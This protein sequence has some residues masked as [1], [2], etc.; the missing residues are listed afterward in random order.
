MSQSP[1]ADD[2]RHRDTGGGGGGNGNTSG[3]AAS[4]PPHQTPSPKP[5]LS[6][7]ASHPVP[8]PWSGHTLLGASASHRSSSFTAG[9]ALRRHSRTMSW[10]TPTTSYMTLGT[11][12][13]RPRIRIIHL[14]DTAAARPPALTSRAAGA[15]VSRRRQRLL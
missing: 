14:R 2:R 6:P 5:F 9:P 3:R 15:R 1:A 10:S 12:R 4:Q 13:L 8:S 7:T 11:I